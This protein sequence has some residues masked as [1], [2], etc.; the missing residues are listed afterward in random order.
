MLE[1][2]RAGAMDA[3]G[4]GYEDMKALNPLLIYCSM[5][6]YGGTGRRPA[7]RPMTR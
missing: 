2:Y 6:G 5:T 1:N 3:I 4:L 7:T